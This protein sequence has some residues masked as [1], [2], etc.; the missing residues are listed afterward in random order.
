MIGA[1]VG[2]VLFS[3]GFALGQKQRQPRFMSAK[4]PWQ[5]TIM[6]FQLLHTNLF[7]LN[8]QRGFG[9]LGFGPANLVYDPKQDSLLATVFVDGDKLEKMPADQLEAV[10]M[11]QVSL[12]Q[13][14]ASTFVPELSKNVR[15]LDIIFAGTAARRRTAD[16]ME[17]RSRPEDDYKFSA[18]YKNSHLTIHY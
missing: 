18:E 7:F 17:G 9:E 16:L 8:S 11:A 6:D 14:G 4:Q 5:T 3:F 1:F 12:V 13:K 10:L 15:A 2:V